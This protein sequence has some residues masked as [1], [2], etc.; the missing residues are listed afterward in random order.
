[1]A[2]PFELTRPDAPAATVVFRKPMAEPRKSTDQRKRSKSGKVGEKFADA[3]H[4]ICLREG[5]AKVEKIAT[6]VKNCGPAGRPGMFRACYAAKA[7]VDYRGHM[8]DGSGRAVYVECKHVA[9]AHAPF[10]M[11]DMRAV[12]I[13]QLDEA[14]ADECVA[15]LLV[16]RGGHGY[17][18]PWGTARGFDRLGD[19]Q[20]EPWWIRPGSAYLARF[21]Q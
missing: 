18:I 11:G 12:Q 19:E 21:A 15:V 6:P 14:L 10:D 20:L 7:G 1:M 9:D 3:L 16:V 2:I 13:A 5:I 8:R 4:A 17:A